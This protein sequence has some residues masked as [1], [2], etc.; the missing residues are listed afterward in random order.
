MQ[1]P[2]VVKTLVFYLLTLPV[3]SV[4]TSTAYNLTDPSD[5]VRA[6]QYFEKARQ[7][8]KERINDSAMVYFRQAS[9]LFKMGG[10]WKKY[11]DAEIYY[12]EM[13]ARNQLY[14][15]AVLH[16]NVLAIEYDSS[17]FFDYFQRYR[18]N[19][20]LGI[21][22]GRRKDV[23]S[24]IAAFKDNVVLTK[25]HDPK[26]STR[27]LVN[28]ART[29]NNLAVEFMD[30]NSLE[31]A[32]N[33]Y[34]SALI[35]LRANLNEPSELEHVIYLNLGNVYKRLGYYDDALAAYEK[36]KSFFTL[37]PPGE[38][39]DL[40]KGL[41]Y[42][43]RG[44]TYIYKNDLANDAEAALMDN[45]SAAFYMNKHRPD[46]AYISYCD[47][48][49]AEIYLFQQKYD[50]A[51][52]HAE[53]AQQRNLKIYG[54]RYSGLGYVYDLKA[55]IFLAQ[56]N[57][58]DAESWAMKSLALYDSINFQSDEELAESYF[59][60]GKIY[61]NWKQYEK[62]LKVVQDGLK[63][64]L[65]D[66]SPADDLQ[67]PQLS[68]LLNR[69]S[70]YILLKM[71]GE[72]LAEKFNDSQSEKEIMASI[73]CFDLATN[74]IKLSR[75]EI[76][77]LKSR[78]SFTAQKVGVYEKAIEATLKGYRL[79]QNDSLLHLAF[80]IADRR[81]S[82]NLNDRLAR[83]RNKI[84]NNVP[85]AWRRKERDLQSKIGFV[86][87]RIFDLK[88]DP[89]IEKDS[90][91][92]VNLELF[93]LKEAYRVHLDEIKT[94]FPYLFNAFQDR[95]FDLNM[96]INS[97][98]KQ[99]ALLSYFVGKNNIYYFLLGD[100]LQVFEKPVDDKLLS[101][102]SGLITSIKSRA[103]DAALS[104]EVAEKLINPALS[105]E[106][107]SGVEELIVIPD[108]MLNYIPYE[109]LIQSDPEGEQAMNK[110]S[111]LIKDFTISYAYAASL[112]QYLADK[113]SKAY[114]NDYFGFAPSFNKTSNPLLATRS[115]T[116]SKI[117]AA[118]ENLPGTKEE[119]EFS[120]ALWG[121][122]SFLEQEAT[123]SNFKQMGQKAKIIHLASH[124]IINDENP[125]YSKLVFTPEADS[126]E[127]GLLYTY[128]LYNMNLNAELA[129]LSA[130]NTGFGKI[131]QGEGVMSLARGFMYAGVPNI[132]MS[133][134]SVPDK[135]SSEIMK[136]FYREL[137]SGKG[138]AE[139]LRL[140]K[141]AYLDKADANTSDP[142]YWAAFT[143]VGNNKPL[144][145]E[146]KNYWVFAVLGL[147]LL[148]VGGYLFRRKHSR[149]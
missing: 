60:M 82:S 15:S 53:E 67:N 80:R 9:E 23:L 30:I 138:K 52:F 42:W 13:L 40:E 93:A 140:A 81:K 145:E 47:N 26:D 21:I 126:V 36:S 5:S 4:Q 7:F 51:M 130:C 71:K 56:E 86:E 68:D 22:H 25:N 8:R 143:L 46:H 18:M 74:H 97:R 95:Q 136:A 19:Q 59:T 45:D 12:G 17:E 10:Y 139:A 118:L 105:S 111:F 14:D 75:N 77:G 54:D 94:A 132:L 134:W 33:Y 106:S 142:Y 100:Q 121:G 3:L 137:K 107:T 66:F 20:N 149:G 79:T 133:L 109:L 16:F 120:A 31:L 99:Q 63:K 135:S 41:F 34:D 114:A 49:Y 32:A 131:E 62:A 57:Y 27:T 73:S 24:S 127:D 37:L 87:K 50:K 88:R 58:Q 91:D 128:E 116:D 141:L 35:D 123:E 2:F 64:V 43:F 108:A 6:N 55:R 146:G 70:I 104:Y 92:A 11:F 112:L 76:V 72:I 110:L 61:W 65:P 115:A 129:C 144:V 90:V 39:N 125:M 44:S 69:P 38:I 85:L 148:L 119:I 124:A 122:Q 96:Y 98:P 89:E 147:G 28:L 117:A 83:E 84:K 1:I 113:T 102:I 103:F 101:S 48:N 78:S 29:F